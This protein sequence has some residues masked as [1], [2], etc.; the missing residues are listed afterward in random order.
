M[1]KD[2]II[3][4]H[5]I[6]HALKN[7]ERKNAILYYTKEAESEFQ[8]REGLNLNQLS[9]IELN[10]VPVNK[11]TQIAQHEYDNAGYKFKRIP[12]NALLVVDKLEIYENA[13][14]YEKIKESKGKVF[15]ALDQVTDVQN[16][17]AILRTMAFFDCAGVII[18][19]KGSFGLNP[20]FFRIAS[21]ATEHV[22]I[23][24]VSSLAKLINK[25]KNLNIETFGF[26]EHAEKSFDG[27]EVGDKNYLLCMG[28][29]DLGLSNAVLR[30]L[31]ETYRLESKGDIKS[32]NVS[33]A[34]SIVLSK[35]K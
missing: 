5:S 10:E 28:S 14:L 33:V 19:Q 24:Q 20:N 29:E 34:T 9:D 13:W 11:F 21:G 1:E 15:V 32:L 6:A 2:L 26:S 8:S 22:P 3:G 18:P 7:S 16:A 25:L 12:S 27:L 17:A 23:V 31:D 35:L 4:I 30:S